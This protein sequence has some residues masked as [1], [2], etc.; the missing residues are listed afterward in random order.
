MVEIVTW[1]CRQ[2][3]RQKQRSDAKE[4][5][6]PVCQNDVRIKTDVRM[7]RL[8]LHPNWAKKEAS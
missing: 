7:R 5:W 4:V 2:G 8:D 3:H 6:C 1:I